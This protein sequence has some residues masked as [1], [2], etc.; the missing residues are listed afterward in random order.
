MQIYSNCVQPF[1]HC[2]LADTLVRHSSLGIEHLQV[3]YPLPIAGVLAADAIVGH[4]ETLSDC[5]YHAVATSHTNGVVEALIEASHAD[6]PM[7]SRHVFW[8]MDNY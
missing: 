7:R 1:L 4:V 5:L 8:S 2:P 3:R 6:E